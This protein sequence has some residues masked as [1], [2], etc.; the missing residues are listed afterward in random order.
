MRLY[1]LVYARVENLNS[2]LC[3]LYVGR[4]DKFRYASANP[5]FCC[6]CIF[7]L[8]NMGACSSCCV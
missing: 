8:L 3:F 7:V 6:Y 4:G 2:L 5:K 1:L